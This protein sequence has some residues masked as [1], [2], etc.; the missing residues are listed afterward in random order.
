MDNG[1][2]GG[3]PHMATL[4]DGNGQIWTVLDEGETQF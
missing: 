1:P 3:W 2:I 4:V